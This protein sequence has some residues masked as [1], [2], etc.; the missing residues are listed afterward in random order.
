[1]SCYGSDNYKTPNIDKLASSGT[2]FT[3]AFTGALC[4]PSRALIVSGHYVCRNGSSNQDACPRMSLSWSRSAESVQISRLC[5]LN[6]RQVLDSFRG[7]LTKPDSMITCDSKVAACIG[8]RR[9]TR[10]NHTA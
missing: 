5:Q 9:A 6:D 7:N 4:G 3:R 2:R 1:M 8:M 10:L